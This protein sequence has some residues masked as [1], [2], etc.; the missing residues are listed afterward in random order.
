MNGPLLMEKA[1]EILKKLNVECDASFS[2]GWLY[3]FKLR[4]GITGKTLSGESGYVECETVDDWIQNHPDSNFSLQQSCS[5]FA[6]QICKLAAR[7]TWQECKLET[8][9]RKRDSHHASNLSQACGV[10]LIANYSKNRL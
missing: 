10:K 2:S 9:E 3:N 5:N 8:S 1:Q 6:L 7:L 4:Q